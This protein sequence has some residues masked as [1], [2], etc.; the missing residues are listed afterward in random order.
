MI[1]PGKH[2]V[3]KCCRRNTALRSSFRSITLGRSTA[4]CCTQR[5]NDFM[6]EKR[7]QKTKRQA[8]EQNRLE[9]VPLE[10]LVV[11][12][13]LEVNIAKQSMQIAKERRAKQT[14]C[15]VHGLKALLRSPIYLSIC[16]R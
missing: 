6:R 5:L 4:G 14:H 16:S 2:D 3:S 15:V 13:R 12:E 7:K 8:G 9:Y 10:K 1:F 11:L